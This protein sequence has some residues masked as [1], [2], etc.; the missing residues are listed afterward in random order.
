MPIPAT[1][2]GIRPLLFCGLCGPRPGHRDPDNLTDDDPIGT[3][4]MILGVELEWRRIELD[5]QG[6]LGTVPIQAG[7]LPDPSFPT[8]D[9]VAQGRVEMLRDHPP[10][11]DVPFRVAQVFGVEALDD[12]KCE[13]AR[14]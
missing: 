7:N 3:D 12:M 2:N 13:A 6:V 8:V 14:H 10:P 1:S 9:R 5:I 11:P 4:G